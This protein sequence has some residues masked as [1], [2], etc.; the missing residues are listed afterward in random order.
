MYD[1]FEID[2]I[3]TE[4]ESWLDEAVIGLKLC[5]FAA[6]PRLEDKI[7][8]HLVDCHSDKALLAELADECVVLL[9]RDSIET[10]LLIVP[11][12][13]PKFEDF[14]QFLDL[15]DRLLERMNWTGIFQIASF[16]PHFQFHDTEY[17]DREN[18]TNR[19]PYPVLH[20]LRE[21]SLSRAIDGFPGVSQ[22]PA[23]NIDRL[24]RLDTNTFKSIFGHQGDSQ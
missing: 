6:K 20:I 8:F 22:I 18:W 17:D 12:Y 14:N 24:N 4:V 7:R 10:T 3:I 15:A 5:P 1:N 23:N 19:S 16:H 9:N 13:L 2:R 21:S 11:D